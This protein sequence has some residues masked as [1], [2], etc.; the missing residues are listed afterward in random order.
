MGF[1]VS[2]GIITTETDAASVIPAVS[3]S[4]GA[5]AGVFSWGPV[6]EIVTVGSEKALAESFGTPTPANAVDF[7]TAASFLLYSNSLR[8][9]RAIAVAATN[10]GDDVLSSP[11]VPVRIDNQDDFES[12]TVFGGHQF[13]SK[14]PGAYGN[15]LDVTIIKGKTAFD[16]ALVAGSASP[17]N[18]E[19]EAIA[20]LFDF[21]PEYTD[22]VAAT[23]GLEDEFHMAVIDRGG[24]FSGEV[25]TVLETFTGLSLAPDAKA[26]DGSTLYYREVL[27]AGSAYVW[28]VDLSTTYAN[29]DTSLEDMVSG[30][31]LYGA[32]ATA[33]LVLTGGSDGTAV[34]GDYATALTLFDDAETVDVSLM[35]IG[36]I[37]GETSFSAGEQYIG[38]L[39]EQRKD[40]V[41]F[42][43]A[44][45][46]IKGIALES[47]KKAAVV[48]KF[49]DQSALS[50]SY[51]MYD[52]SPFYV[53][54]KYH[55]NYVYIPQ[56]GHNAGLCAATDLAADPWFSPGGS[57]R[58]RFR[59][60]T[61]LA[62]NPGK[63]DR[64]DLYKIGV[65]FAVAFP[66][67]GIILYGDKTAQK[68]PSA[69]DRINVRRLFIVLEKAIARAAKYQLF[70]L[71]DEFTRAM[72][73][74]MVEPFL[75]DVQ[76]RRGITDFAVVCDETNNTGEVIDGNR[77]VAS[78]FIAPA[79]SINFIQLDFIATRTGVDFTEIAGRSNA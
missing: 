68:K 47:G 57:N 59:G 76:G 65:N 14:F 1:Q 12:T 17:A 55:D 73:R 62:Y 39:A 50:S 64:D 34:A 30:T 16:A 18:P 10:A 51:L 6:N 7:L 35:F 28:G 24:K 15:S 78:I 49:T 52:A 3:T 41:G 40:F 63:A 27:K 31:L 48:T 20:K 53:Y 75:R 61:K 13:L 38:T 77:F 33:E 45:N 43:S 67:E 29:A 46:S 36:D 54:N 58:G 42:V 70:E 19:L 8:V 9:S 22:G 72:F 74:N 71:N 5:T 56:C 2:P 44:P 25:G 32:S 21:T 26:A 23:Q 37:S 11:V 79:R 69:F 4:I 60:V 66:G